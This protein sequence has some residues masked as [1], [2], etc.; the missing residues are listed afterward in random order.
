MSCEPHSITVRRKPRVPDKG[1]EGSSPTW[2]GR[3]ILE[4]WGPLQVYFMGVIQTQQAAFRERH[5]LMR[6]FDVPGMLELK[7]I[8]AG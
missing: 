3:T 4:D 2:L 6:L 5:K 8:F 7:S 1:G